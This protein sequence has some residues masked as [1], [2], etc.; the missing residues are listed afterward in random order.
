MSNHLN[1]GKRFTESAQ[2]RPLCAAL[3]T[4]SLRLAGAEKQTVYMARALL[5]AGIDMR[6]FYLGSGGYYEPVLR[7]MGIPLS[8]IYA[9]NRPWVIL[10]GLIRALRQLRPH[11]VL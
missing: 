10:A 2:S 1:K 9:P 7:Q 5:D 6:L 3:V 11:I 4:S 8:Q